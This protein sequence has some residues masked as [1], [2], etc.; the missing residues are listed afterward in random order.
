M[1]KKVLLAAWLATPLLA[2]ATVVVSPTTASVN[3]VQNGSFEATS[4][5]AGSWSI[6]AGLPGWN[7]GPRGVEV[8][9]AVEG[10]AADGSNFVELDTDSNSHIWQTISTTA[11]ESYLLNFLY[12]PRPNVGNQG[13]TND[14]MVSWNGVELGRLGGAGG[15]THGWQEIAYFVTGT[16]SDVLRFNALGRSDSY[17]GSLDGVSLVSAVQR[18]NASAVPEPASLALVMTALL[19]G[20]LVRRRKPG[21]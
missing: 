17:G 7:A 2:S 11:G 8:R 18:V 16:G 10:V 13:N 9:N 3:L 12:S 14:I 4:Q 15:T 1:K 20:G 6:Y 5:A 21:A 19:G